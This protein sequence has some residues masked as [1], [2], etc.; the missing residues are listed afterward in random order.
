MLT[1]RRGVCPLG[2]QVINQGTSPKRL[3]LY[4]AEAFPVHERL[5]EAHI[6]VQRGSICIS[7]GSVF[8]C[9]ELPF[10]CQNCL[11]LFRV[12]PLLSKL[13]SSCSAMSIS[14]S[15]DSV[16]SNFSTSFLSDINGANQM[17][18]GDSDKQADRKIILFH[19]TPHLSESPLFPSNFPP[20]LHK[21]RC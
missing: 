5:D 17:T 1:R 16:S 7:Y 20:H 13:P 11:P 4:R 6:L 18:S 8:F 10:Q 2:G 15:S 21:Q 9:P 3:M 14:H 19:L 12:P